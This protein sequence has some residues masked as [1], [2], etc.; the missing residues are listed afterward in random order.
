M[1]CIRNFFRKIVDF[2]RGPKLDQALAKAYD[3]VQVALPIV[4]LVARLTPTRADDEIVTLI[5][6]YAVPLAVPERPMTDLEK[7]TFLRL[8]ATNLLKRELAGR[9]VPD[10]VIDLAIQTAY[11][12]FKNR[13]A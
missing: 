3:L 11:V 4:E 8:T 2:F 5:Q 9:G 10:S 1:K 6:K 13:E 12:A 7:S